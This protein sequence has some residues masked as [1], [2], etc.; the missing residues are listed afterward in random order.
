MKTLKEVLDNKEPFNLSN[1]NTL[2]YNAVLC[3]PELIKKEGG[4]IIYSIYKIDEKRNTAWGLNRNAWGDI[5]SYKLN[6]NDLKPYN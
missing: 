5:K 6:T 1:K 4:E 3:D 2:K